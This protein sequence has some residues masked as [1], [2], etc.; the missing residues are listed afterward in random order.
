[1][2]ARDQRGPQ[3][4]KKPVDN[5]TLSRRMDAF[6]AQL[7]RNTAV[8]E[9]LAEEIKVILQTVSDINAELGGAP[10]HQTRGD[11]PTIRKRLHDVQ[12]GTSPVAIE[13][14]VNRAINQHSDRLWSAWQKRVTV[15]GVL[16]GALVG[17]LRI[18]GIGG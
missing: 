15:F 4:G 2:L 6:E 1:M 18:M 17:L 8:C 16:V 9:P 5:E 3:R 7:E 10:P 14:A 12:Q 13:A 11:R